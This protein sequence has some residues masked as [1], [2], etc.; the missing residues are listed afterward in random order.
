M[1]DAVAAPDLSK[2]PPRSG[3][4]MLGRYAWLARLADKVRAEHAGT[5]GEYI[6]YCPLSMGFLNRAGVSRDEFDSLVKGGASDE[7]LVR[8]FDERVSFDRRE[9]ANRYVLETM[10]EHLDEEDAEEGYA[11]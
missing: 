5:G 11:H 9:A 7:Q 2:V 3:R 6:A 4:T 10:R 1:P 8:Y